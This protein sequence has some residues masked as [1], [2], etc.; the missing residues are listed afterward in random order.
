MPLL[1]SDI[2]VHRELFGGYAFLGSTTRRCDLGGAG[3]LPRGAPAGTPGVAERAGLHALGGGGA[4]SSGCSARPLPGGR[5]AMTRTL[6][7]F[8]ARSWRRRCSPP[9]RLLSRRPP[10]LPIRPR[11]A[12]AGADAAGLRRDGPLPARPAFDRRHGALRR[13]GLRG[14]AGRD[15][16]LPLVLTL[17]QNS[18]QYIAPNAA[19]EALCP[20]PARATARRATCRWR[21]AARCAAAASRWCCTCRF[22]APQDDRYLD[23]LPRRRLEQQRRP[24]A[25][26][27]AGRR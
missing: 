13:R 21:S 17:G 25:S 4:L 1:L 23:G 26:S 18:G 11:R 24:R 8:L 15:A 7:L 6:R 12:M 22:R 3:A 10:F 2:P 14:R 16:R 9:R 20:A 27:R 5:T 19:L